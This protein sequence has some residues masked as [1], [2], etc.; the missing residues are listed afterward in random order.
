M[1]SLVITIS[2]IVSTFTAMHI[3]RTWLDLYFVA[4]LDRLDD[5]RE[6]KRK[7]SIC[8]SHPHFMI[9]DTQ[10]YSCFSQIDFQVVSLTNNKKALQYIHLYMII[11]CSKKWN[12]KRKKRINLYTMNNRERKKNF[13]FSFMEF[14]SVLFYSLFSPVD[15]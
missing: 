5:G 15:S 11:T 7:K 14:T 13:L 6:K 9:T 3:L 8:G 4:F 1:N 10:S 2:S 12:V